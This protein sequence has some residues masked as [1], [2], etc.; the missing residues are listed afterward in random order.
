MTEITFK[1]EKYYLLYNGAALFALQDIPNIFEVI[2]KDFEVFC[3]VVST[4]SEQGELCRR[5]EGHDPGAILDEETLRVTVLPYEI[6]ELRAAA[7]QAIIAGLSREV[8][9]ENKERDLSLEKL[10]K[11]LDKAKKS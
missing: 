1:D 8:E 2:G 11:K 3:R 9:E 7:T 6:M 10:K 5:Y 4:L